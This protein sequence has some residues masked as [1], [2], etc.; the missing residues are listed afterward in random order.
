MN[1]LS[2]PIGQNDSGILAL[3]HCSGLIV[4][5]KSSRSLEILPHRV[6]V[7]ARRG[8]VACGLQIALLGMFASNL[9]QPKDVELEIRENHAFVQAMVEGHGPVALLVDSGAGSS[10]L[11]PEIAEQVKVRPDHR[12]MIET[13]LGTEAT[14]AASSVTLM[15]GRRAV[16]GLEVTV[17]DLAQLREIAPRAHGVLG[18]DFLKW[19]AALIDHGERRLILGDRARARGR[20]LPVRVPVREID[21]VPVVEAYLGDHRRFD[22]VL[23]SG[24]DVVAIRCD[25][26]CPQGRQLGTRFA[27]THLGERPVPVLLLSRLR[28][29][30]V[31]LTDVPAVLIPRDPL[32]RTDGVVPTSTFG[33]AYFDGL[34]VR[35]GLPQTGKATA[36]KT[37]AAA[38]QDPVGHDQLDSSPPHNRRANPREARIQLKITR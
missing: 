3:Q 28:I 34:V 15:V 2:Q 19:D 8:Q 7:G 11:D 4:P 9:A 10:V 12:V 6:P 26:D 1:R 38:P 18:Y 25:R 33:A 16:G 29:G 27:S 22:L 23:D 14:P 17:M 30:D 31:I 20:S 36:K 13:L 24:A 5:S 35:L 32:G 21:G 37:G